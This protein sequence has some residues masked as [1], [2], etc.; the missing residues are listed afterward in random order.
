[1]VGIDSGD[2]LR[3]AQ[4]A[5]QA[6]ASVLKTAKDGDDD[7]DGE[8]T[9]R[10]RRGSLGRQAVFNVEV[11]LGRQSQSTPDRKVEK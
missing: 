3:V 6:A 10:A 4:K 9:R 2:T 1:M 8:I 7:I 11:P 5:M